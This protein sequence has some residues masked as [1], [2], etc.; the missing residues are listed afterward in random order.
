MIWHTLIMVER[1]VAKFR[2]DVKRVYRK[3][4]AAGRVAGYTLFARKESPEGYTLFVPPG[5]VVLFDL[6]PGW[7]G[8]LLPYKGTPDLRG[9]DVIPVGL[10]QP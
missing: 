7:K 2:H 10:S 4:I 6:L 3:E 9:F 8:R 5:A 1:E